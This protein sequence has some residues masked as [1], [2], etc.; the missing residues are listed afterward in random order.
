MQFHKKNFADQILFSLNSISVTKN[1]NIAHFFDA[2]K[3]TLL[4]T[5]GFQLLIG[6]LDGWKLFHD[7]NLTANV[8][9]GTSEIKPTEG[10]FNRDLW[11]RVALRMTQVSISPCQ[12]EFDKVHVF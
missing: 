6:T 9:S 4:F 1:S 10:N 12:H 8:S 3:I 2:L 7:P 11:K 5:L